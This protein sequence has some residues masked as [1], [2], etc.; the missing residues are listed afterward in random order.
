M[1]EFNTNQ[2]DDMSTVNAEYTEM[3]SPQKPKKE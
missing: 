2:N 1:S 3:P